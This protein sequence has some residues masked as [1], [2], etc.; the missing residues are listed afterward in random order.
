M[1]EFLSPDGEPVMAAKLKN[2]KPIALAGDSVMPTDIT[3]EIARDRRGE[4]AR[5]V[6]RIHMVLS[7]MTTADKWDRSA[8]RFDENTPPGIEKLQIDAHVKPSGGEK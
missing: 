4:R 8:V 1:I 6:Q 2:Y 5:P 7:Q 3:L